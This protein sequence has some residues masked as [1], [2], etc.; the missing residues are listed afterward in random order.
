L[1]GKC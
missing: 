1:M